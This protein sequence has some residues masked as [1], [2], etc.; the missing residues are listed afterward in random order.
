MASGGRFAGCAAGKSGSGK[1]PQDAV[2][3]GVVHAAHSATE[4]DCAARPGRHSMKT[5]PDDGQGQLGLG[6]AQNVHEA[7]NRK[8]LESAG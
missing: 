2:R 6:N 3:S 7:E 8:E 1:A 5:A 4:H